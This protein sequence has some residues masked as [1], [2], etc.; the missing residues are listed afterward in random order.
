MSDEYKKKSTLDELSELEQKSEKDSEAISKELGLDIGEYA[1]GAK[2][3]F[4][5]PNKAGFEAWKKKRLGFIGLFLA[6][7][8]ALI[9]VFIVILLKDMKVIGILGLVSSGLW[10]VMLL[11]ALAMV[12]KASPEQEASGPMNL[13]NMVVTVDKEHKKLIENKKMNPLAG[14]LIII[15]VFGAIPALVGLFFNSND[16]GFFWLA[17]I[18]GLAACTLPEVSLFVILPYNYPGYILEKDSSRVI[19]LNGE[20]HKQ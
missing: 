4:H 1:S 19:C 14:L 11:I 10:L 12:A 2:V 7:A 5:E 8:V 20:W 16:V 3:Y 15:A 9:A 6:I 18:V 17:F 13:R